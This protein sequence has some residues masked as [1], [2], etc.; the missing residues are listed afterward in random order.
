MS[1]HKLLG[2]IYPEAT[3]RFQQNLRVSAEGELI[4][5]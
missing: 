1:E 5:P 4:K 2:R 3:S